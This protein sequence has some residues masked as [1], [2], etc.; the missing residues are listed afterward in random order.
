MIN[1]LFFKTLNFYDVWDVTCSQDE[2]LSR[3][4]E[5]IG[6]C[7]PQDLAKDL[8]MNPLPKSYDTFIMIYNMHGWKKPINKL[9]LML[10]TIEKNIPR[11][12]L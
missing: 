9:H 10:K 4:I 11:K 6:L 3:L 1:G 5:N 12:P 7:I 2:N 8:I